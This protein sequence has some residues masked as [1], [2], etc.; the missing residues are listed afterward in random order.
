MRK[1]RSASL[2]NKERVL[3][4]VLSVYR[5]MG[6]AF[7][8]GVDST[9]LLAAAKKGLGD[10]VVAF[11]AV[12]NIHPSGEKE[13]AIEMAKQLGVRHVL[14]PTHELD[15]PDFVDNGVDRCYHCKRQLF[16][17]ILEQ[18]ATLGINVIAHGANLDDVSDVRPGFRAARELSVAAPLIDAGLT[19]ADVRQ[20]ARKWGLANWDRPSM[21]CLATRIPYGTM[22]RLEMLQQI[23][24]AEA[25]LRRF[26]V[27]QCRVRHYGNMARIETDAVWIERMANPPLRQQIVQGLQALGYQHVCL[28]LEG[29]LSGKMNRGKGPSERS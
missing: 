19:K 9:L 10:R 27:G 2:E 22:I 26:G 25:M 21:A 16:L 29:Y 15:N 24:R 11:T 7:S 18:S 3:K 20:L 1:S 8:G 28:D 23:D 14:I 5:S 13:L 6:V 12:S 4:K 17:A